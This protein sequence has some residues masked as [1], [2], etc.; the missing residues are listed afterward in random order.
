MQYNTKQTGNGYDDLRGAVIN[1]S[2]EGFDDF[3]LV[4]YNKKMKW[5]GLSAYYKGISQEF[6]P[7]ISKINDDIYYMSCITPLGRDDVVLNFAHSHVHA[8]SKAGDSTVNVHGKITQ[9]NT[10]E[11]VFPHAQLTKDA[12][13]MKIIEKNIKELSLDPL[14][15]NMPMP[16]YEVDKQAKIDL[17]DKRILI[18]GNGVTYKLN[19]AHFHIHEDEEKNNLFSATKMGESVYF[20]TWI[21]GNDKK[22][23]VIDLSTKQAYIHDDEEHIYPLEV[24]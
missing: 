7:M 1:Y 12:D 19:V 16:E 3:A 22:S 15:P 21:K 17:A 24:K 23:M 13:V 18:K 6:T 20:V 9:F 4:I 11:A 8:T 2:Y 10:E 5:L 14:D